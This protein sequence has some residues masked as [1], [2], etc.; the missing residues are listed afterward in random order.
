MIRTM[1]TTTLALALTIGTAA[2]QGVETQAAHA[3]SGPAGTV[4]AMELV[5]Q[6]V[7]TSAQDVAAQQG[8]WS[9]AA[10][11][12]RPLTHQAAAAGGASPGSVGA[13]PGNDAVR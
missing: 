2:A 12:N 8:G 5:A 7:A 11:G 10:D 1:L 4:G 3:P 9:T 6:G 13:M